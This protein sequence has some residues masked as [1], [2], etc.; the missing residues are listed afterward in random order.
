MEQNVKRPFWK[1]KRGIVVICLLCLL[2]LNVTLMGVS[3]AR[4]TQTAAGGS[5][6]GVLAFTPVIKYGDAWNYSGSFVLTG[7]AGEAAK[8]L[9]F[10]VDNTENGTPIR[11]TVTLTAEQ[12]LPL[13]FS[14]FVAGEERTFA[15]GESI[16][17]TVDLDLDE[18]VSFLLTAEW[19]ADV[20]D[21]RLN[22]ITNDVHLSV[23]CEQIQEVS[24]V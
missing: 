11:V 2:T 1:T 18:T 20:Y 9:P 24:T 14:L 22:G 19:A 21:E 3:L 17:Y 12:V 13:T 4:Y 15:A 23:V 16:T 6:G 10:E 5:D 7:A 8:Q